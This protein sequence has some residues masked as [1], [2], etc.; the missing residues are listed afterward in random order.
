[1]CSNNAAR[2]TGNAVSKLDGHAL[3]A[4][5]FDDIKTSHRFRGG[6]WTDSDI[7]TQHESSYASDHLDCQDKVGCE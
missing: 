1:M 4:I 3:S 5:C 6:A 2:Q 7:R